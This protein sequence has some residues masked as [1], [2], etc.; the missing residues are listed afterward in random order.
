V[1][2]FWR[3]FDLDSS[4]IPAAHLIEMLVEKIT[5]LARCEIVSKELRPFRKLDEDE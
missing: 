1:L 3:M 2:S 5:R 4:R